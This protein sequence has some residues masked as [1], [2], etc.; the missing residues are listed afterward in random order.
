MHLPEQYKNDKGVR[1]LSVDRDCL[2]NL[3][4]Y[5]IARPIINCILQIR[6]LTKHFSINYGENPTNSFSM[7]YHGMGTRSWASM[8]TV[9]AF[10]QLMVEKYQAEQKPFFPIM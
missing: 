4:D 1:K 3:L 5:R 6:D 10:I 8:L 2:E 9:K 7:E